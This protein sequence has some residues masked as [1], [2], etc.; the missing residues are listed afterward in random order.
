MKSKI[1]AFFDDVFA[2]LQKSELKQA[3]RAERLGIK[4]PTYSKILTGTLPVTE[5]RARKWAEN[6]YEGDLEQQAR[7][8]AGALDAG[9]Q[10]V[11]G[12]VEEFFRSIDKAG[13]AV[14]AEE[15]P[16]LFRALQTV[17]RA[18]IG[19]EYRDV[20][21]A[22]PDGKYPGLGSALAEA[23][24]HGVTF[25]MFQPFLGG[26]DLIPDGGID[27]LK[28]KQSHKAS[29]YLRNVG[30]ECRAAYRKFRHEAVE[31][32]VTHGTNKARAQTEVD[33]RLKLYERNR[34]RG[35]YVG[36]GLQA[37]I[38]FIQYQ[39]GSKTEKEVV[40]RHVLQ[41][42]VTPKR[43]LI[44][45][46]SEANIE[47]QAIKDTF[48]PVPH[49]FDLEGFL[50]DLPGKGRGI[51]AEVHDRSANKENLPTDSRAWENFDP[52]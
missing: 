20:P 49:F 8:I 37:R 10:V 30:S 25:A 7:F 48:F 32:L 2:G 13:G 18:F 11:V 52:T 26:P 21:R 1:P 41:W 28:K 46:R 16:A 36:S 12:S 39:T 4:A 23:I 33:R 17:E 43:D 47:A 22:S 19:V 6:L 24:A 50:P 35:P 34:K 42:I 40:H 45:D 29:E 38:F 3:E 5:T 9:R 14:Q 15:I 31:I 44:V 27:A 51:E